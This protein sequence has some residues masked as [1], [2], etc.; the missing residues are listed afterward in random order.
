MTEY[1]VICIAALAAGILNAMA[2]GGTLLTYPALLFALPGG[3]LV[4]ANKVLANTTS[5]VALVPGS[6]AAAWGYRHE[7]RAVSHWVRLLFWPSVVGG[8]I[9][10]LMVTR[11][12]ESWFATLVPWLILTATLLFMLQPTIARL[13]GIGRPHAEPRA[14]VKFAVVVFQFFVAVYGG[15]FGGGIGILMLSALALMGLAD[16]HQMN[17]AKTILA[18]LMNGI[19]AAV[20]IVEGKVVWAYAAAMAVSAIA[21]GYVGARVSRRV[22]RGVVRWVVITIGLIVTAKFFYERW[23]LTQ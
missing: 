3:S 21:G 16:I 6:I 8:L 5:T 22:S 17:A 18:G 15:Y 12:P 9:G 7:L 1:A 4:D 14:G 20:F 13:T 10:S 11:L 2:G 19:S 23:T